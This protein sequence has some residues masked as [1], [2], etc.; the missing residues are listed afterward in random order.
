[1]HKFA[2]FLE[3]LFRLLLGEFF[4]TGVFHLSSMQFDLLQTADKTLALHSIRELREISSV[5]DL[6]AQLALCHRYILGFYGGYDK[7]QATG[8]VRNFIQ[9]SIS[10]DVQNIYEGSELTPSMRFVYAVLNE[11]S[12]HCTLLCTMYI[13]VYISLCFLVYALVYILLYSLVYT[14]VYILVYILLQFL[15][16]VLVYVL[17][18]ISFLLSCV[19]LCLP[20]CLHSFV[21][22]CLHPFVHSCLHSCVHSCTVHTH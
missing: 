9:S 10:V 4:L 18:Y 22:S 5:G 13:L 16:Y 12:M 7:D 8:Y 20:P 19:C 3:C 2:F 1:M 11:K 17:G 15:V 14:L 21:C 6:S